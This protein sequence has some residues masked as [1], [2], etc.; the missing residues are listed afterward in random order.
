VPEAARVLRPGGEMVFLVN[1]TLAIL[2]MPDEPE[3]RPLVDRMLRPYFGLHRL[4]WR[5]D[6]S[7]NFCI[8]YGAWIRL[9][10]SNGFEVEDLVEL[11]APEGFL[12]VRFGWLEPEW[13][14]RWPAEEIWKARKAG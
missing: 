9:L 13:A 3:I 11:Q 8:G 12:G 10:R 5:S 4:D 7:A 14:K 2:C 1:G 6:D